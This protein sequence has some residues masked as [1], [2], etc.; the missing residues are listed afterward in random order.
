MPRRALIEVERRHTLVKVGASDYLLVSNDERTLWRVT[1]YQ[2]GPSHGLTEWP[3]DRTF[4][5]AWRYIGRVNWR[6][7][8]GPLQL[9]ELL[10]WND[11]D[12]P[13]DL[14][15]KTRREA[16]ADALRWRP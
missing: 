8:M 16:I 13:L 12:G 5:G 2:D 4:W 3:R 15:F 14:Y 7:D 6:A 10:D 11:W 9:E 1:T